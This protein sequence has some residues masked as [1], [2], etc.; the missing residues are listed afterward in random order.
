MTYGES[1]LIEFAKDLVLIPMTL[2][3][4]IN[5]L[6]SAPVFVATVGRH[7]ASAKR[8]ARQISINS[9]FVI[10]VSMLIGTYVL[11]VFGISLP[12]VRLGGG[13]LVAAA[14]WRMLGAQHGE[15]EMHAAAV[16]EARALSQQEILSRSF[17]PMTFPLTTGP[18]TIAASIAL[19]TEFPMTTPALYLTGL[20]ICAG[21]ATLVSI[22]LY[23]IFKNAAAV[24]GKLGP[25]GTL[26]MMRLMSF[27]LLCI[28]IQIMWNGWAELNGIVS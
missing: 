12:I 8:L 6:S 21:G 3:P 17:F 26:V 4:I 20:A 18:G 1:F 16:D 14:A 13:L 27:I 5:P 9:W 7:P 22:V 25:A 23:Y 24:L 15:D 28:G 19:G 11:R 2:L 10:V